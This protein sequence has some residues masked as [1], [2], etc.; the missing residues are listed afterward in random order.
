MRGLIAK[1]LGMSQIFDENGSAVPVTVL[2][3]GPCYITQVKT[4]D[5]DGY[6]AVQIAYGNKKKKNTS[7]DKE[8]YCW[9]C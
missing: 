8:T 5:N 6:D 7:Q 3:A 1:K 2:E 9:N 4:I